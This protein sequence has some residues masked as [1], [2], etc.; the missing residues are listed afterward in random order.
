MKVSF[1]NANAIELRSLY[2]TI[3]SVSHLARG[4]VLDV[5]CGHKPYEALF[6]SFYTQYVGI[7]LETVQSSRA[8]VFGDSLHLP[9][10]DEVFD[11]VFSAQVLEHVRNPFA[12]VQEIGRVLKP[13]GV[14][15]LTAPQAWPLHEKP[16]DFFRYTRYGLEEI[17]LQAG[18]EVLEIRER[19]GGICALT[20]MFCALLY[21]RYGALMITRLPLKP[22]FWLLQHISLILDALWYFPDLTLG[23]LLVAR[24]RR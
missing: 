13:D 9:F 14:L 24:K 17:S 2:E 12:M 18:F 23:Y 10:K 19:K 22:I 4:R 11:T 15:L 7:D 3:R 16:Y 5:G 21:D 20:E 6:R 1:F 8:D